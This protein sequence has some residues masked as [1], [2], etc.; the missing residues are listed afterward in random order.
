MALR[1][2]RRRAAPPAVAID[3]SKLQ[4]ILRETERKP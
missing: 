1:I 3:E 2:A 4:Q